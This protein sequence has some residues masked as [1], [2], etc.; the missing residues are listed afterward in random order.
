[1][2][3]EKKDLLNKNGIEESNATSLTLKDRDAVLDIGTNANDD[4]DDTVKPRY[5][6]PRYNS[7]PR[8]KVFSSA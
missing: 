1:M 6:M 7:F 2:A 4:H 8:Y 5:N 3:E